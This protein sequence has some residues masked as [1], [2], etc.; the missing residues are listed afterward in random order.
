M[1]IRRP[2]IC[3]EC[4]M[5]WE[6]WILIEINSIAFVIFIMKEKKKE[7]IFIFLMFQNFSSAII[8]I[9]IFISRWSIDQSF[10]KVSYQFL[11]ASILLKIGL[12]PF[13]NWI[14]KIISRISW[15]LIVII[16]SWQKLI[17][18]MIIT[19]ITEKTKITIK[20]AIVSIFFLNFIVVKIS[21]TKI[22]MTISSLI[23]NTWLVVPIIFKKEISMLYLTS[24]VITLIPLMTNFLKINIK[25]IAQQNPIKNMKKEIKF[26]MISFRGIPPSVGF[27]IKIMVLTILMNVRKK[28]IWICILIVSSCITFYVYLQMFIKHFLLEKMRINKKNYLSKKNETKEISWA[29]IFLP[30][31]M[32]C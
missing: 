22:I 11:I 28:L 9:F 23:H 19:K 13:H 2:I 21:R 24:Y 5:W 25:N 10:R 31:L 12:F 8:I 1:I 3:I 29:L 18:I 6:Y 17:P 16:F 15:F 7:K 14:I 32:W 26:L 27:L 4:K 20:A 30:I